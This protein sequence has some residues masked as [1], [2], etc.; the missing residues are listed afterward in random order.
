[1]STARRN[2][3][4]PAADHTNPDMSR[5]DLLAVEFSCN[6]TPMRL[7]P[8]ERIVAVRAML[9]QRL[10]TDI[11]RL[12][13]T[14]DEEVARI[15]RATPGAMVCPAGRHYAYHDNGVLRRH[16]DAQGL[17]WCAQSGQH[18]TVRVKSLQAMARK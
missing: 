14:Y 16:V 2:G 11:A 9:G 13:G 3:P 10:A 5:V 8:D 18:H 15:A 17:R 6:G 12:I 7:N 4:A 1:M